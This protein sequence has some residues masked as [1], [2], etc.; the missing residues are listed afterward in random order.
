MRKEALHTCTGQQD[1]VVAPEHLPDPLDPPSRIS[2]KQSVCHSEFDQKIAKSQS[3]STT[4]SRPPFFMRS[5]DQRPNVDGVIM[6]GDP[7]IDHR[8]KPD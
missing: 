1:C 4:R 8:T 3:E 7:Q 6:I 5:H 2:L